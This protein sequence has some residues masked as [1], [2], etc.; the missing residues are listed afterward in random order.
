MHALTDRTSSQSKAQCAKSLKIVHLTS[1]HSAFDTRIFAKECRSLAQAGFQV[2]IIAPHTEDTAVDGVRIKAVP[3]A[4]G[5]GRLHRMTATAWQVFREACRQNGDIYHFHDPE[6]IPAALALRARGKKV[7]YDIHEN[8]PEDILLKQYLPLWSRRLVAWLVGAM[9][10]SASH[11]FSA[12]VTVSPV[13]AER[14]A[15]TNPRTVL[16]HNFPE[17]KELA[18][19]AEHPWEAREPMVAFPGGI[20]PE[21]GIREMVHAMACFP[22]SANAR[23]EIASA[24]FP[25]DL[26][27]ELTKHPGWKRVRYRGPLNRKQVVEML[28]RASAGLVLYLPEG[29]NHGA[30]PHKL[31]EYMAAG[32][33]VIATDLKLWRKLLDGIDCVLFVDPRKPEAIAEAIQYV[34]DHPE[35]AARMGRIG[36]EAVH[37]RYNWESQARELVKLYGGLLKI[38]CAE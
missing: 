12:L 29:Q 35:E 1:V 31:F 4:E 10:T 17:P 19:A 16:I 22:D 7:V 30:M 23:L 25:K 18:A 26:W 11:L 36:R 33:P 32:I 2:V 9:E 20:L 34:I 8:V 6:L 15:P 14:F 3:L 28:G 13:I 24:E 37:T 27:E 21:R 38:P 5:K